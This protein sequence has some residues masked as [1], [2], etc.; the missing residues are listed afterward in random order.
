[1][2]LTYPQP[3]NNNSRCKT[4]ALYIIFLFLLV[5][6]VG[7][8][9]DTTIS[10]KMIVH[11]IDVGQG[12]A[13]L[14]QAPSQTILVDGGE[15]GTTVIDYLKKHGVT[16]LDMVI[17]THPHADHIG[18]LI[19][20]LQSIPVSEVIDPG[21]VHTTQTYEDYLLLIDEKDIIFTEG[22]AGMSRN[23]GGG[24]TMKLLHPSSPT[25]TD[26]NEVSVVVKLT[27][28][29][30]SFMLTGDA[31]E[32]TEKQ[33]LN[34]G[35][36]VASTILKVGHHGSHTSTSTAFF[37]AVSP[38]VAV[39]MVGANSYGH[40]HEETLAKLT[41]AGVTIYR[42]D[43]HGSIVIT[44]DGEH[45]EVNSKET[46]QYL[47]IKKPANTSTTTQGEYVGSIKSDKYHNLTC[48]HI[49]SISPENEIS[50]ETVLEA[51]NK[52]YQPCGGCKPPAN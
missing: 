28:G 31:E 51:R 44:T 35:Y 52:N 27:F 3:R 17:G 38:E 36:N 23:L 40:P 19:N 46:Y 26:V 41:N 39:I 2:K 5:G 4:A 18:G 1:M 34:A 10:G 22:R 16:K 7:C 8:E 29:Q 13:I 50:F 11:F 21:V 12:D 49:K 14:I 48:I 33:I 20:V 32:A 15:R 25:G 42:S 6:L 9:S 24:A 45:Y 47:P 43:L 37:S 30:V